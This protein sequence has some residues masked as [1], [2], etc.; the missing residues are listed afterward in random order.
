MRVSNFKNL[1]GAFHMILTNI[2]WVE[3][4]IPFFQGG[5][6]RHRVAKGAEVAKVT[7]QINPGF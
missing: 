7:K 3:I 6:T 4:I 1:S 5:Q 2:L